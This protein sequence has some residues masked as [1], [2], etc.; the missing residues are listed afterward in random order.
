MDSLKSSTNKYNTAAKQQG[1]KRSLVIESEK[2]RSKLLAELTLS[3]AKKN[4]GGA[5]SMRQRRSIAKNRFQRTD[6]YPLTSNILLAEFKL[7]RTARSNVS[8]PWFKKKIENRRCY[9]AE[10]AEKFEGSS[11]WF[12]RFKE[13]HNILLRRRTNKKNVWADDGRDTIQKFNRDLRKALKTQRR[14]N[15]SYTVDPKYGRWIPKNRYNIDLLGSC[16]IC[17]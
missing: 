7:R 1:V 9:G 5:G 4:T 16:P 6:K 2:N 3:K 12:H 17:K 15:K 13:R 11:N 14:R 8:K 10:E